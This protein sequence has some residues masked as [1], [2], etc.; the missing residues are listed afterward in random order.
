M[1][2][3]SVAHPDVEYVSDETSLIRSVVTPGA[4]FLDAFTPTQRKLKTG[5]FRNFTAEVV[6]P[7][8]VPE[9]I[10]ESLLRRVA[11]HKRHITD[12]VAYLMTTAELF[13]GKNMGRLGSISCIAVT[14][15]GEPVG[16]APFARIIRPPIFVSKPLTTNQTLAFGALQESRARAYVV[17]SQAMQY[18]YRGGLLR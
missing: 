6:M 1:H 18:P 8:E 17:Q 12:H 7:Y 3:A 10:H 11:G 4:A 14:G 15:H 13:S 9:K 16:T 5:H 2:A